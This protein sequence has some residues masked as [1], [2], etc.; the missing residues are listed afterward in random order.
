MPACGHVAKETCKNGDDLERVQCGFVDHADRTATN[1]AA[2]VRVIGPIVTRD[3]LG[4]VGTSVASP[5][6]HSRVV[7]FDA[8]TVSSAT[9]T[10][11]RR[12]SIV[13]SIWG[14]VLERDRMVT[15]RPSLSASA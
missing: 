1:I 11:A 15:F 8:W 10:Q 3:L 2:R 9:L 6:I 5:G 4:R 12:S 14:Q 13:C 7:D